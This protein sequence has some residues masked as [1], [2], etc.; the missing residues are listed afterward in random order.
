MGLGGGDGSS[1]DRDKRLQLG[2]GHWEMWFPLP[3]LLPGE[4]S[5]VLK[6]PPNSPRSSS[7]TLVTFN[8]AEA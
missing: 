1:R 3:F 8:E 6:P 4:R 2:A 7:P 5:T